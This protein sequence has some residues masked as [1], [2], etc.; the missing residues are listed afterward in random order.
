[1]NEITLSEEQQKIVDSDADNIIVAAGAGS[2]KTRVLTE[3]VR[4]LLMTNVNPKGIVVITFTNM[5]AEE[6]Q[7]RLKDV[8]NIDKCF[9]GTIHSLANTLLSSKYNYDLYTEDIQD[10]YMKFLINHFAQY[11]TIDDYEK[12]LDEFY[13][14][15]IG[16]LKYYDVVRMFKP[17]VFDELLL[18]LGYNQEHN[19]LC[20]DDYPQDVLTL[21]STNHIITFDELL[22][23]CTEYFKQHNTDVEYLFVD[24][25]QDVGYLEYEFLMNLNAK[26]NFFIGDDYQAIYGFKGGNV[27]I[28]LSL[29]QNPEYT[30]YYLE[31]NYRNGAV[32]LNYANSIISNAT[33]ILPK[34]SNCK[35]G[36][37][38][39][40][41]IK[42]K[43]DFNKFLSMFTEEDYDK[44]GDWFILVR[45]NSELEKIAKSLK[46]RNIPT[47]SF[48]KSEISKQEKDLAMAKN[49]I[50]LLTIHTSKGL[51]N[52]NVVLYGSFPLNLKKK[53]KSDEL[54]IFYVGITRAKEKLIIFNGQ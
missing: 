5:A 38:G 26:H 9:I 3:R 28:F 14:V 8:P 25:L 10:Y 48:R 1:M 21:C 18:L 35:S 16:T 37:I 34:K 6:L 29:L 24:E 44:F 23:K 43:N 27:N 41:D 46:A 13:K 12:L 19:T 22:Q 50:K 42:S 20:Y 33:N 7:E 45:K 49:A 52:E 30:H 32:I 15:S 53:T 51:E 54:K 47:I 17:E 11:A 4:K 31:D 2:G 39:S 36:K 40:V